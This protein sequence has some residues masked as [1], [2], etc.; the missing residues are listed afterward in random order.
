MSQAGHFNGQSKLF[1]CGY[2]YEHTHNDINWTPSSITTYKFVCCVH[3]KM[4][5]SNTFNGNDML[6]DRHSRELYAPLSQYVENSYCE[7]V[8]MVSSPT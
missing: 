8:S 4:L 7:Y 5:I 6:F 2:Q 3:H 1:G